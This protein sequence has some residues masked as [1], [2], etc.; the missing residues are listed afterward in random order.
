[1]RL[2]SRESEKDGKREGR[3]KENERHKKA[4]E[5]NEEKESRKKEVDVVTGNWGVVIQWV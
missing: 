3:I 5:R 2:L 4:K 1:M